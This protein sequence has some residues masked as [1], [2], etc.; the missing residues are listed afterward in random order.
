MESPC[1]AILNV[2][3]LETNNEND[4]RCLKCNT[5]YNKSRYL[6]Q[7]AN[8]CNVSFAT[9][10]A[11]RPIMGTDYEIIKKFSANGMCFVG[12]FDEHQV[13]C[14]N[15]KNEM[16]ECDYKKYHSKYCNV[17]FNL[18]KN[19]KQLAELENK[20]EAQTVPVIATVIDSVIGHAILDNNQ[21]LIVQDEN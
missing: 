14:L 9:Q 10:L 5:L 13:V 11:E 1:R 17:S 18:P 16:M 2:D 20:I 12:L 7:H 19:K 8:V 15:C 4:Y 21:E 6:N 3:Y